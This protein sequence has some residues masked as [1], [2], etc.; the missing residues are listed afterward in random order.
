VGIFSRIKELIIDF[1]EPPVPY[2]WHRLPWMS[3]HLNAI[4]VAYMNKKYRFT[5]RTVYKS[6]F[7][8]KRSILLPFIRYRYLIL[9]NR[10]FKGKDCTVLYDVP[11]F[12]GL[13]GKELSLRESSRI[14]EKH[15]KLMLLDKQP[16]WYSPK[17]LNINLRLNLRQCKRKPR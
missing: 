9:N 10:L 3:K 17:G 11:N 16:A 12:I 6:S 4:L 13:N 7:V 15:I 1:C 8:I 5:F 2:N 14:I